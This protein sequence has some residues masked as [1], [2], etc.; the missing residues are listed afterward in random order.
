MIRV[1][2]APSGSSV[3]LVGQYMSTPAFDESR[4][5]WQHL[6]HCPGS[7]VYPESQSHVPG[8]LVQRALRSC[9]GGI[10]RESRRRAVGPRTRPAHL[11]GRLRGALPCLVRN[12][13]RPERVEQ[14]PTLLVDDSPSHRRRLASDSA[15][16]KGTL[17]WATFQHGGTGPLDVHVRV[18]AA[19][20]STMTVLVVAV[21]LPSPR[22]HGTS[23]SSPASIR[24]R[25]PRGPRRSG[26]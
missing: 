8:P 16:P 14:S 21:A 6:D 20:P 7:A 26:R 5:G 17:H 19:A 24:S 4:T 25:C 2:A 3:K 1:A 11:R 23:G 10:L 12:E 18:S 15:R 9:L 22:C 13:R